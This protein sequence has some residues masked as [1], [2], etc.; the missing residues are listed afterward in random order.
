MQNTPISLFNSQSQPH[1]ISC[2][3]RSPIS[4]CLLFQPWIKW[5]I[6]RDCFFFIKAVNLFMIVLATCCY[7]LK[8]L[9]RA[10]KLFHQ[11]SIASSEIVILGSELTTAYGSFSRSVASS[12]DAF[13]ML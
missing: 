13:I 10:L 2:S 7:I 1:F 3:I 4:C 12:S 11:V 6:H 5:M 9:S 8:L